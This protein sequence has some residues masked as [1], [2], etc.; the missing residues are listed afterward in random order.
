MTEEEYMLPKDDADDMRSQVSER[1]NLD[2][3]ECLT[4]DE[5]RYDLTPVDM[6]DPDLSVGGDQKGLTQNNGPG[7]PMNENGSKVEN[8]RRL[9]TGYHVTRPQANLEHERGDPTIVGQPLSD[10][11][12]FPSM[13]AVVN[14]SSRPSALRRSNQ[15]LTN[16]FRSLQPMVMVEPVDRGAA[17]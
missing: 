13:S 9:E 11:M 3:M 17:P 14:S 4:L 16:N 12:S 7:V 5:T 1:T 8:P 2:E 10:F 6:I 15:P